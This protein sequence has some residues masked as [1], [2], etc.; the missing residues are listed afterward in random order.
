LSES[1]LLA[2]EADPAALFDCAPWTASAQTHRAIR[3]RHG[4]TVRAS[5]GTSPPR[6]G[7]S[8][9]CSWTSLPRIRPWPQPD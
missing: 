2:S 3:N 9:S 5:R 8:R 7:G 6:R 4:R 1:G